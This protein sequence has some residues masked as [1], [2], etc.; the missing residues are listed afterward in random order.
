MNEREARRQI[1][2][3][4]ADY[5][6]E[7]HNKKAPFKAGDRIPYASRV[8]DEQEMVNLVDS[9]LEFWLTAGRYADEFEKNSQNTWESVSV[10]WLIPDLQP[11]FLLLWR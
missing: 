5:C 9:A 1:L 6:R 7:Y 11:I 8:Y 3:L 4:V 10:L 2:D